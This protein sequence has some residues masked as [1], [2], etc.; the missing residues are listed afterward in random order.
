MTTNKEKT[1]KYIQKRFLADRESGLD[2]GVD[3]Q[4]VADFLKIKRPNASA[5]LNR[6]V[7]EGLLNKSSTRP[8]HYYLSETVAHTAFDDLVGG[9]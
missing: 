4:Q 1:Y 6:L 9:G 5:I 3:T 8:V 7:K 2:N